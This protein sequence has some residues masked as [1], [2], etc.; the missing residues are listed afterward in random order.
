VRHPAFTHDEVT[1]KKG[2]VSVLLVRKYSHDALR[3]I[4]D[5]A[6]LEILDI[7]SP[8]MDITNHKKYAY[9]IARNRSP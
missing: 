9:V 4:F 3:S 6:A 1:I 8:E 7:I 2:D 5:R